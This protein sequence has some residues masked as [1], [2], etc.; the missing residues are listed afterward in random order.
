MG[1]MVVQ[2]GMSS[3]A[4]MALLGR[5]LQPGDTPCA[6]TVLKPVAYPLSD[7]TAVVWP[8]IINTSLPFH[9]ML[10]IPTHA[11]AEEKRQVPGPLHK[12]KQFRSAWQGLLLDYSACI[13]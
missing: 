10:A 8:G 12:P 4:Y 6:K 9:S 7:V 2:P 13:R 5:L 11:P 3:V 1:Y